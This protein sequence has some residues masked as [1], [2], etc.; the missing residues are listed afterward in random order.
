MLKY[1]SLQNFIT[2]I[3]T[4][5]KLNFWNYIVIIWPGVIYEIKVWWTS[6]SYKTKNNL[7]VLSVHFFFFWSYLYRCT[8]LQFLKRSTFPTE[9]WSNAE[10]MVS[11]LWA[12][13]ERNSL[14]VYER[15]MMRE[16]RAQM[17]RKVNG[18]CT[19]NDMWTLC[20]R[21]MNDLFGVPREL[22][23]HCI[24]SVIWKKITNK[25]HVQDCYRES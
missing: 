16:S 19:L 8:V 7:L 3:L 4:K 14:S 23:L 12:N 5:R 18:E 2:T 24:L 22:S 17:E 15:W 25:L 1:I 6:Q 10:R 9:W 11:A 21:K 13:A 20:K